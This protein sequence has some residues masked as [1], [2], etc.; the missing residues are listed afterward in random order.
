[1]RQK[2]ILRL[3]PFLSII[4][5][6]QNP[7]VLARR[8]SQ[9]P[10]YTY[11]DLLFFKLISVLHP[12]IRCFNTLELKLVGLEIT[13]TFFF[14]SKLQVS[15]QWDGM[16]HFGYQREQKFYNGVTMEQIHETNEKGEKSCILGIS[17]K[18]FVL[19][20]CGFSTLQYQPR[21]GKPSLPV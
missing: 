21:H 9:R 10:M 6:C 12:K 19:V 11:S 15:S 7:L 5:A 2:R 16:R 17:G 13:H 14:S 20:V 4:L 3:L 8:F 1:M 18:C